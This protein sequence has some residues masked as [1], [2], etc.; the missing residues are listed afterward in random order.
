MGRVK[1][2]INTQELV[3]IIVRYRVKKDIQKAIHSQE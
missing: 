2:I 1:R 3:I